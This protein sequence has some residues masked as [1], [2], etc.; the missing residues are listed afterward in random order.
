MNVKEYLTQINKNAQEIFKKSIDD[1]DNLG[2]AHH[3]SSFIGEFSEYVFDE[4]EK[5]MIQTVAI[6][7]ESSTINLIFGMYREALS[8][9]RLALELGLG[10]IHFSVHKM[11]QNEWI[12]GEND[13]KWSKLI[14]SENGI[15][16]KRFCKAFFPELSDCMEEYNSESRLIYR[17]MSEFVHGNYSTWTTN[18]LQLQ[19]NE[20]LK[21]EYFQIN[22][23][24]SEILIFVLCCRYLKSLSIQN[25]EKISE[26]ILD[27]FKHISPI[28]E[29][30]GGPKEIT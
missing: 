11:E 10:T 18:G 25:K 15:L 17:N 1:V 20:N 22:K 2:K 21:N 27:E 19:Y 7:L 8:S 13:I 6:Q 9:L 30:L 29:Y 12:N 23:K 26:F 4:N 5:K 24:V 3:Y 16:S 14:D 28:R